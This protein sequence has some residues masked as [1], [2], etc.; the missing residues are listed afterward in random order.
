MGPPAGHFREEFTPGTGSMLKKYL[1]FLVNLSSNLLLRHTQKLGVPQTWG[2]G[3]FSILSAGWLWQSFFF[4]FFFHMT[5]VTCPSQNDKVNIHLVIVNITSCKTMRP[6]ITLHAWVYP[7]GAFCQ[8]SCFS[9]KS[10]LFTKL[11]APRTGMRIQPA[12]SRAIL[13]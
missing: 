8:T 6:Q 12:Y 11:T 5:T 4:P 3:V 2:V 7:A 9:P 1:S 13:I 10:L